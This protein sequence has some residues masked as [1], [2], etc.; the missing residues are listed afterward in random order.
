MVTPHFV[1]PPLSPLMQAKP[2]SQLLIKG[3]RTSSKGFY[4][5][6]KVIDDSTMDKLINLVDKKIDESRDKILEG[7]FEINPKKFYGDD[8]TIGC[9]FCKY[10]DICF[11]KNEDIKDLK[12]CKDLSFLEEGDING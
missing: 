7:D 11:R 3:L 12:K 6:S 8:E 10:H 5:S 2:P 4:S 1:A 9:E